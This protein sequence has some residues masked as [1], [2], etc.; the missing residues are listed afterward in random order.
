MQA[1]D[2]IKNDLGRRIFDD[3]EAL[4][5]KVQRILARLAEPAPINRDIHQEVSQE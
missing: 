1:S 5:S 3:A 2:S 4:S